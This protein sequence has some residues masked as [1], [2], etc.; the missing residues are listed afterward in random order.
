LEQLASQAYAESHSLLTQFLYQ[1]AG[2][3][4]TLPS[5]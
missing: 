1:V 5:A 2:L 3:L 4:S